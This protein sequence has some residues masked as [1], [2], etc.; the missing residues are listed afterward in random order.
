MKHSSKVL[1]IG[2]QVLSKSH[3]LMRFSCFHLN[4]LSITTGV[5]LLVKQVHIEGLF[6]EN[7]ELHVFSLYK[8]HYILLL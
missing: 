4:M 7:F 1:V 2:M 6:S 5:K 3:F 8:T